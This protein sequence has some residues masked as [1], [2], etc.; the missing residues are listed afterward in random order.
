[1][2]PYIDIIKNQTSEQYWDMVR[3]KDQSFPGEYCLFVQRDM[4]NDSGFPQVLVPA[5]KEAFL[6]FIMFHNH[7]VFNSRTFEL[8]VNEYGDGLIVV[9]HYERGGKSEQWVLGFIRY[10]KPV[11]L[12]LPFK[13]KFNGEVGLFDNYQRATV[14]EA[15]PDDHGAGAVLLWLPTEPAE[16]NRYAF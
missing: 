14:R 13:Q 1:M 12:E 16:V 15:L 2:H 7:T 8:E 9:C 10:T 3:G 5:T 6:A 4:F 11:G